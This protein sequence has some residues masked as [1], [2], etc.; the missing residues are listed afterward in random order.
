MPAQTST[1]TPPTTCILPAAVLRAQAKARG[2]C[3]ELDLTQGSK[4]TIAGPLRNHPRAAWNRLL[5]RPVVGLLSLVLLPAMIWFLLE[6]NRT[7]AP[8]SWL[9]AAVQRQDLRDIVSAVGTLRAQLLVEVGAQVT[10]QVQRLHVKPGDRVSRG[11]LL[12]E[13]DDTTQKNTLRDE[14]A[15]LQSLQAQGQARQ[16][17]V[18]Y[19]RQTLARQSRLYKNAAIALAELQAAQNALAAAQADVRM[20]KAQQRQTRIKIETAQAQLA[21]TRILAPMAGTVVALSA[22]QGQTLNATQASPTLLKLAQIDT[23]QIEAQISEAD[24]QR[25]RPGMAASFTLFGREGEAIPTRL[26]TIDWMP[27]SSAVGQA[28]YYLGRLPAD[29]PHG[30]LRV[31]MTV[32]VEIQVASVRQVL[33]MPAAALGERDAQ[34]RH[35]VLVLVDA[36]TVQAPQERW[37]RIGLNNRVLVEVLEGLQEG[38]QVITGRAPQPSESETELAL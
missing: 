7:A 20:M 9:T 2:R 34:G 8:Q 14:Q 32:Q 29:N 1:V 33:T 5:A 3:S 28:V 24:L 30:A 6:S 18:V 26:Q 31:G 16:A 36:A 27:V 25:V 22:E 12:I 10:G 4:T 11:Q 15:A 21:Y 17:A 37:V 19:A 38:E 13:I 23:L 35:R